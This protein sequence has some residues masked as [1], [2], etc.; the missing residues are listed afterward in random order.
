MRLVRPLWFVAA[1]CGFAAV[2]SAADLPR[3]APNLGTVAT[4]GWTGWY[5]GGNGGYGWS[6]QD[7]SFST[8]P[9]FF[10]VPVTAGNAASRMSPQ[11]R[12]ALGGLQTGFNYQ[13]R[14]Y[15][16]GI[17]ADFDAASLKGTDTFT[18]PNGLFRN[19]AERKISSLGTVR[20]RAGFLPWNSLLVYATGGLAYGKT[21]LSFTEANTLNCGFSPGCLS[22]PRGH[23]SGLDIGSRRRMDGR[24]EMERQGRVFIRGPRQPQRHID[25]SVRRPRQLLYRH[26]QFPCQHCSRRHQLSF[27]NGEYLNLQSRILARALPTLGG[28]D[29]FMSA[30]GHS[31]TSQPAQFRALV[32]C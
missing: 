14:S 2:A 31:G 26:H 18:S 13:M 5:V 15:V 30:V 32:R 21:S 10:I 29:R 16:V 23:E 24:T 8:D 6:N 11:A 9:F 28:A 20:A 7:V 12:G 4:E 25:V 3:K 17:E 19:T 27:L 22:N 1:V